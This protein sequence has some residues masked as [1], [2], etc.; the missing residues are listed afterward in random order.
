MSRP[1]SS[2]RSERDLG[3]ASV[4]DPWA[5]LLPC[6]C[7]LFV[8]W[9]RP[10]NWIPGF[11]AIRPGLLAGIWGLTAVIFSSNKRP[12]P[13]VSKWIAAFTLLLVYQIPMAENH[14]W[15]IFKLQ[16]DF[17][18]LA[19]GLLLPLSV[20][21]NSVRAMRIL[22]I[23]FFVCHVPT[24]IHGLRTGG[25]GLGSWFGDENDLAFAL[26][27]AIGVG[28]FLF[29]E[30]REF[31]RK[32]W[33]A[34]MLGLMVATVVVSFSRGGLLGLA[35]VTAYTFVTAKNARKTILALA[36]IGAV[37][38]LATAS[39]EWK[40]EMG[41]IKTASAAE[42][43]GGMRLYFWGI[44]WKMFKD[45]PIT[46]VGSD[47]FGHVAPRYHDPE[48]YRT[49]MWR[50]VAHSLY[51]TLMA[52][53]GLVGIFI[54]CGMFLAFRRGYRRLQERY[55]DD[56]DDENKRTAAM[57]SCGLAAGV[58]GSLATGAFLSVLYYPP[59]WVL[60]AMMGSLAD[61]ADADAETR[62]PAG[63]AA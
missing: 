37:A 24:A 61:L 2:G 51:I 14:Q 52:E 23:T 54:Y 22:L 1:I 11:A 36:L 7:Y 63:A 21:P 45:H 20:L 19:L 42:D 59:V 55:D 4:L 38:V 29:L 56:P 13:S 48:R 47:N 32:L 62:A 30:T 3:G 27:T 46:G 17:G 6:V 34:A 9:A 40:A 49:N 25:Q 60:M 26:N 12:L 57:L 5:G 18:P 53:Q 31:K 41:T 58:V 8:E 15:A 16:L 50:R 43:T 10:V 44:G 35:A 39:D 33:I 28:F